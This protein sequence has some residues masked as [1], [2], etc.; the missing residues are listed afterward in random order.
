MLT[1]QNAFVD[2]F[3]AVDIATVTLVNYILYMVANVFGLNRKIRCFNVISE[4]VQS[5]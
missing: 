3:H 5:M 2:V 1:L 4:N